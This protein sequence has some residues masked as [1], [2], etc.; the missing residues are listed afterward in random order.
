DNEPAL[1]DAGR[2][3]S[4]SVSRFRALAGGRALYPHPTGPSATPFHRETR[5]GRAGFA[6][7]RYVARALAP[8]QPSQTQAVS[9][10]RRDAARTAGGLAVGSRLFHRGVKG[11]GAAKI[12]WARHGAWVPPLLDQPRSS[13]RI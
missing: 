13:A 8:G 6:Q 4:G 3:G 12:S 11:R 1:L 10:A 7:G 2:S 5:G 9:R